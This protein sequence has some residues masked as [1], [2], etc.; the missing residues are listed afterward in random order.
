[1]LYVMNLL[2]L[3]TTLCYAFIFVINVNMIIFVN[4]HYEFIITYMNV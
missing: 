1:M 2:L 4:C 3:I